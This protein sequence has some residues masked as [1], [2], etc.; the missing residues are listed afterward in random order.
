V[1]SYSTGI[2]VNWRGSNFLEVTGLSWS[3]GGPV[4]GRTVRW[5][6]QAGTLAV[7]CLGAA[8][9]GIGEYGQRGSLT[10]SGGGQSL[11]NTAV[12]ESMQVVSE[13]NGVTRYTVTF[14]LLD[15]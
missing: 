12:W 1:A 13:L 9:V 6:D 10:V 8:N 2:T 14:T 5:T 4:K 11:T 15:Q 7:T 3:Y